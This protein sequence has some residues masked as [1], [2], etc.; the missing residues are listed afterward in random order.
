MVKYMYKLQ[1]TFATRVPTRRVMGIKLLN[2]ERLPTKRVYEASSGVTIDVAE[3][4]SG[5]RA[6]V[7]TMAREGMIRSDHSFGLAM[8]KPEL[9]ED[10]AHAVDSVFTNWDNPYLTTWFTGGWGPKQSEY[11]ANAVRKLRPLLR[12]GGR[13]LDARVVGERLA[14][15]DFINVV[16]SVDENGNFPWGDFPWG[17]ATYYTV[18][19]LI[20]P[21]AVSSL[22]EDEDDMVANLFGSL[23]GNLIT[24][25]EGKIPTD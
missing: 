2:V 18:G 4:F 6:V 9:D 17:G 3:V 23:I 13:T 8:C 5:L 7:E 22:R 21:V 11:I 1:N 19:T 25:I 16:E 24:R 15:G 14:L 12:T 10:I 20:I